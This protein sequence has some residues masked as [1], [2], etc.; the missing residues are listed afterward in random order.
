MT[1][2][3]SGSLAR[4]YWAAWLGLRLFQALDA[5]WGLRLRLWAAR[6]ELSRQ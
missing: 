2:A 5:Q 6:R 1:R 3:S 4:A